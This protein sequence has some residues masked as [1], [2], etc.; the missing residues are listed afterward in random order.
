MTSSQPYR[1]V[2]LGGGVNG[3]CAAFH[4]VQRGIGPVALIDQYKLGHD[5]GSSHG[6][7]RITRSAYVNEDYV[8]LMQ[9]AHLEAW[10]EL[11]QRLGSQLVYPT[12]GCF[13]GPAGGKY[14]RYARAVTNVG[15]DCVETSVEEAR[16]KYPQFRFSDTPGVILDRT[17][18][19]VA[20]QETIVGLAGYAAE[21]IDVIEETSVTGIDLSCSPIELAT[22]SSTLT[23]ESLVVAAGPWVRRL[24]PELQDTVTVARQ[25]VL[26][27]RLDTTREAHGLGACPVWGYLGG[28]SDFSYYGLPEFGQPGIKMARHIV[29]GRDDDPDDPVDPTSAE[30]KDST[31]FAG[32]CF[33][34][35]LIEVLSVEK[36]HYTNTGDE[37]FIIDHHPANPACVIGSGFSGHGFK[38]GP[39]TGRALVD[40]AIDGEPSNGAFTKARD[41]FKLKKDKP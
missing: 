15:I 21:H 29:S 26:F 24:I 17:A 4:A 5:Q 41:R 14:E 25:T 28:D 8:N 38:L 39:V 10:P 23:T 22:A 35:R 34:A 2:I 30:I 18:G 32:E 16:R 11:E 7:S 37:D 6:H 19:L 9:V 13:F 3:L 20:A 33:A 36:C 31:A 12:E 27:L 1:L 40:L